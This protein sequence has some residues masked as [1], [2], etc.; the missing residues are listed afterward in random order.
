M[1][2]HQ[3]GQPLRLIGKGLIAAPIP[4]DLLERHEIGPGDRRGDAV[5]IDP[6]VAPAA[7]AKSC[8]ASR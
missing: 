2:R 3:T 4:F 1:A 7:K 6:A 8:I 5:E